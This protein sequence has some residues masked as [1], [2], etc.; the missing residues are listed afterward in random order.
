MQLTLLK[1]AISVMHYHVTVDIRSQAIRA[2][3]TLY[4][5]VL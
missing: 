1:N 2:N 3:V 5:N 4:V